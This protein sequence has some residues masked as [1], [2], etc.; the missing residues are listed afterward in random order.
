MAFGV[1]FNAEVKEFAFSFGREVF[2]VGGEDAGAVI[3]E[4]DARLR[5]VDVAEIVA[6]IKLRD[7]ADGASEFDAGGAAADDDEIQAEDASRAP[8]SG[9]RLIRRPAG[10]GGGSQWRL[11]CSSG[12]E[13]PLPT[14]LF[15]SRSAWRRWPGRDSRKESSAP[16]ARPTRRAWTSMAFDRVHEDFSVLLVTQDRANGLCDVGWG[17]YSERHLVEQR[18]KGVVVASIDNCHIDGQVPQPKG[19]VDTCKSC[20]HN[21]HAWPSCVP[22]GLKRFCQFAHCTSLSA[23]VMPEGVCRSQML[24]CD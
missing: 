15:R 14:R 1:D 20:T 2:G 3:E 4:Q 23:Y 10:R 12:R 22:T 6:H 7:I 5:W 16:E 13:Q 8:A 24:A 17:E 11:R 9:A 19:G 21:D 18:L